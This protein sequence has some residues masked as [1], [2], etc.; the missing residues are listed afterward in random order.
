MWAGSPVE[1]IEIATAHL[2]RKGENDMEIAIIG[3]GKM[4]ECFYTFS[5][6]K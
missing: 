5:K 1:K 4:G 3:A 2:V 6:T